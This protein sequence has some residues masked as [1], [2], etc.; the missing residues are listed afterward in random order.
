MKIN[1][2]RRFIPV[3]LLLVVLVCSLTACGQSTSQ[4]TTAMTTTAPSTAEPAIIEINPQDY[5]DLFNGKTLAI[6]YQS[7]PLEILQKGILADFKYRYGIDASIS[8]VYI[9]SLTDGLL[10]LRSGKVA[11]IMVMRFTGRYLVQRNNDL[12]IY[13]GED[14]SYSTHMIFSPEKQVQLDR[15]NAAIKAIKE[16]GTL[17]KLTGRW[18]TD[19]PAGEEPSGGAM[20]V[21]KD[22]ET[23][24]VGISGDEPPLDY[25]AADGTP[26]GFNVA[27]LSEIGRR[28]NLNIELVTINSGARFMALQAG[29]LD[30]F[31]WY[32]NTQELTNH[33]PPA[34]T[35]I[36]PAGVNSFLQ[37]DSYLYTRGA[38]L[39]LKK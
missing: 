23:L 21:I 2:M 16:D 22:A 18:I 24:K 12:V 10:M 14:T 25:I 28:A 4:T 31:L 15:V 19:L 17:D 33:T 30:S 7:Q 27:V 38:I 36:Q 32:A 20:P 3:L 35:S 9:D 5:Y 1:S 6:I 11:A 13:G 37:S 39:A 34:S 8:V 26:G 29:R